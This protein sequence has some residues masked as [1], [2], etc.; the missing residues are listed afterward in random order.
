MIAFAG[1][2]S[3]LT[4]ELQLPCANSAGGVAPQTIFLSALESE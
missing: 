4:R 1:I 2:H 3:F